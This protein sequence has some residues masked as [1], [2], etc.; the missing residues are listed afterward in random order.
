MASSQRK[1]P[2]DFAPYC[3]LGDLCAKKNSRLGWF[4]SRLEAKEKAIHHLL[5]SEYHRD[6]MTE[7]KAE[8]LWEKSG[9][10]DV[11]PDPQAANK[12]RK[13][14]DAADPPAVPSESSRRHHIPEPR[15]RPRA[16]LADSGQGDFDHDAAAASYGP[17][18]SAMAEQ[19]AIA[20]NQV[21]FISC[22]ITKAVEHISKSIQ[23]NQTAARMARSA[24]VAFDTEAH[25][26]QTALDHLQM[27]Y[28]TP[29]Q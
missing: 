2:T 15:Q 7:E 4:K 3:P 19:L 20:E 12:R 17:H 27:I 5:H 13:V 24:A 14:A 23:A 18:S 8:A 11:W 16:A 22:N 6:D 25:T 1:E 10:I 29:Q 26:L 28:G 9:Y 21:A